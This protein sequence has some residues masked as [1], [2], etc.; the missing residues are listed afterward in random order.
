MYKYELDN[1][2]E[3]FLKSKEICESIKQ[4]NLLPFV[5]YNLILVNLELK[6]LK[7]AQKLLNQLKQI[8]TETG[9]KSINQIYQLASII[10][11]KESGDISELGNAV[12]LIDEFLAEKDIPLDWRL[13]ALYSLLE[14]RIKELQLSPNIETLREVQKR[15]HHLEV[16][17]EE[18]PLLWLLANI[19]RLQS[20]LALIQLDPQRAIEL[21]NKAQ[22]IAEEIKVVLLK[23]K[24][25]EDR[26]KINQ[27]L[28]MW[29]KL[30]EQKAPINETIKLISLESTAKNIKKD[31]VI[32]ERDKE[33]GK[34]IEY[35]K[36]F[37]LKL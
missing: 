37:T 26:E 19:Y 17:A 33:S 8:S 1:A 13:E 16:V 9:Y 30:Q 35:R 31:T 3:Y 18:E 29:N 7:N 36:L 23:K 15:L 2:Q 12:K 34:V 4:Y 25:E 28:D 24:I 5:L 11:L 21:L 14:I 6:K 32:E 20:R 10:V 22:N 27:Q